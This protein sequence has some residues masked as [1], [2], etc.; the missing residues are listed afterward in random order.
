M[1]LRYTYILP[2]F[3]VSLR[4]LAFRLVYFYMD[5][6]LLFLAELSYKTSRSALSLLAFCQFVISEVILCPPVLSHRWLI[7]SILL[8]Y[9]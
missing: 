4:P 1:I 2:F 9:G 7:L 6:R 3:P 5:D 8:S